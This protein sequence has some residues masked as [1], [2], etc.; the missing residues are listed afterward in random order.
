MDLAD[1]KSLRLVSAALAGLIAGVVVSPSPATAHSAGTPPTISNA[2]APAEEW[3]ALMAWPATSALTRR[4][5]LPGKTWLYAAP[6][7]PNAGLSA[8]LRHRTQQVLGEKHLL[9]NA[10]VRTLPAGLPLGPDVSNAD[11]NAYSLAGAR[12]G[13][14]VGRT[15]YATT[16]WST[17]LG[18]YSV[19]PGG[20]FTIGF[21]VNY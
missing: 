15:V 6:A 17:G 20:Q 3:P 8:R 9:F 18:Q 14:R 19:A 7:A 10:G 5:L 1:S 12:L 2:L 11:R 4:E 16:S 21:A 13:Y